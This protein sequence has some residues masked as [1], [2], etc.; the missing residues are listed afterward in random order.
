MVYAYK[1]P[2]CSRA[3][4]I[5]KSVRDIDQIETCPACETPSIREFAPKKIHLSKTSVKQA[6]FNPGL[7]TVVKNEHHKKELL[8]QKGLVEIGNDYG[9]G[10]KQLDHF[11]QA[12]ETKKNL[13]W[14]KT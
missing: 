5:V 7:G 11:E 10:H 2:E 12:R 14:E 3:F 8:K 9:S 13:E 4:D 6:E 1:C